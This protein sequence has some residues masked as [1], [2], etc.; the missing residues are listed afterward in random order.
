VAAGFDR[1]AVARAGGDLDAVLATDDLVAAGWTLA[2]EAPDGDGITWVRARR[3]FARPED[4]APL[5]AVIA[6]ADGPFQDF[7][8]ERR[9]SFGRTEWE[10]RGRIDFSGGI[11]AFGDA[12]LA[13][14]LDG[15]PLGQTVEEIEAQ[16]GEPLSEAVT[17][18][19]RVRL[20][21]DISSNAPTG[22][23]PEA[24]WEVGFGERS[25]A[26]EATGEERRTSSLVAAGV[27]AASAG[28]LVLYGLGR[29]LTAVKRRRRAT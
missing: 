28:V 17:V 21:G 24:V 10:L 16:L 26:L 9:R 18:R 19:V 4:A 27:G 13:A 20:P 5:F 29:A 2:T 7:G 11:E 8:V 6:G 1:E 14:E 3:S 25:L 22:S 23:A 12:G 15:Q